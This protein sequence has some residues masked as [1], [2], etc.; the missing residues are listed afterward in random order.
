[1]ETIALTSKG[2]SLSASIILEALK[3]GTVTLKTQ[4]T[5]IQLMAQCG[6]MQIRTAPF[7]GFPIETALTEERIQEILDN[8]KIIKSYK[9]PF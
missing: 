2:T 7:G 4:M 1:M 9:S 8:N 6:R 3:Y 5:T